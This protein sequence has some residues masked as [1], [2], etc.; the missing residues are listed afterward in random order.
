[1][2]CEVSPRLWVSGGSALEATWIGPAARLWRLRGPRGSSFVDFL[3]FGGPQCSFV[4]P[5]TQDNLFRI[6]KS[7]RNLCSICHVLLVNCS[8]VRNVFKLSSDGN[9]F[10]L[11]AEIVQ[12]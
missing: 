6:W 3:P 8:L 4:I 2:S 1:M 7:Y 10:C 12:V 5:N 11:Y 9:C